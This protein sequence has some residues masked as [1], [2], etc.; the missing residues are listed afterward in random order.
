MSLRVVPLLLIL[1]A[2][3]VYLL[4]SLNPSGQTGEN[5]FALFMAVI[6]VSLSLVSYMFRLENRGDTPRRTWLLAGCFMVLIL[7]FLGLFV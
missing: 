1:Q 4:W 2:L 3:S 5:Q 6:F 7:L